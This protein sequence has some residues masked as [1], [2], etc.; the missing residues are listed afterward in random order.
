MR[1]IAQGI[2]ALISFGFLLSSIILFA[3]LN[4]QTELSLYTSG[5][6]LMAALQITG[7]LTFAYSAVHLSKSEVK[8]L[9]KVSK[10]DI[11]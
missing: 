4:A 10:Y 3:L 2:S 9:G 6:I 1:K 5:I 11:E 8:K 7:C